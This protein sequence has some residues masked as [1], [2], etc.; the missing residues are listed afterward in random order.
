M[1]T[2]TTNAQSSCLVD[3]LRT[4]SSLDCSASVLSRDADILAGGENR[5]RKETTRSLVRKKYFFV[6]E[7]KERGDCCQTQNLIH[8]PFR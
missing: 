4:S 5:E 7:G 2:K 1:V 3:V 8:E 6:G